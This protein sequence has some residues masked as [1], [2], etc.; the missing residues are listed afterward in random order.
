[1]A[2]GTR[3]KNGQKP[4]RVDYVNVA[5]KLGIGPVEIFRDFTPGELNDLLKKREEEQ[6]R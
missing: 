6:Q 5:L 2:C 4:K 3:K 1:M